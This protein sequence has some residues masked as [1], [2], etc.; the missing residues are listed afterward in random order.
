M[1]QCSVCTCRAAYRIRGL[2]R[3]GQIEL[4]KALGGGGII[5]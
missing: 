5:Q 1:Y 3:E 2:G 4:P